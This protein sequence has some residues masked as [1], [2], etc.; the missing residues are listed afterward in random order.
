M[1]LRYSFGANDAA[2]AI[3]TVCAR[4]RKIA[5]TRV[6][7]FASPRAPGVCALTRT[8]ANVPVQ[9]V[10]AAIDSGLRTVDVAQAG[11]ALCSTSQFG[12][13]VAAAIKR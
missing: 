12:D 4:A 13:A 6:R 5:R 11:E 3:E 2:A 1:M 9:A 10:D 7:V 8:C